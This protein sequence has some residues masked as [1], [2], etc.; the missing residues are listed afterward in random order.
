MAQKSGF[1][2]SVGGDRKYRAE[3]FADY[4]QTIISTGVSPTTGSLAITANNTMD[5]VVSAGRAYIEG[6]YYSNDS[7]YALTLDAADALLNRIDRII[8]RLDYVNRSI[9]LAVLKG[10]PASSPVAPA[11][12]RDVDKYELCIA[13]VLISAGV[14]GIEQ[15][16]VT[17]KRADTTVCGYIKGIMIFDGNAE[18]EALQ[19]EVE[20]K[21]DALPLENRRKIILWDGTGTAPTTENGNILLQYTP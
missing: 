11:F 20:G 16:K 17:D 12:T 13:E 1:F 14:S 3:E 7:D 21:Q 15:A 4:F 5:L 9:T 10:T 18:L 19:L 2:N 8:L 6:H